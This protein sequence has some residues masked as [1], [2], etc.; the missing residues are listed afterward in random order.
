MTKPQT[1]TDP[2]VLR[3][4]PWLAPDEASD[5]ARQAAEAIDFLGSYRGCNI[6]ARIQAAID[7]AT[8]DLRAENARLRERLADVTLL[9]WAGLSH[10]ASIGSLTKR[11]AVLGNP[12]KHFDVQFDQSGVPILTTETRAA[13]N[14]A[15]GE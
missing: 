11:L 9:A 1:T 7:A 4:R 14:A 3:E 2:A 8:A 10:K 6:E 13:L 5:H 12:V 15:K